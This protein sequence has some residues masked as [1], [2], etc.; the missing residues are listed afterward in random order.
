MKL[1]MCK[2]RRR[3]KESV[4]GASHPAGDIV[5]DE[6]D[7]EFTNDE[8]IDYTPAEMSGDI[9]RNGV[10]DTS[11]EYISGSGDLSVQFVSNEQAPEAISEERDYSQ[12]SEGG[13]DYKVTLQ[14]EDDVLVMYLED[15]NMAPIEDR[16]SFTRDFAK[17]QDYCNTRLH[18]LMSDKDVAL[19]CVSEIVPSIAQNC[20]AIPA[21]CQ[22][23]QPIVRG[24]L[25]L[26]DYSEPQILESNEFRVVEDRSP[27]D[28][29]TLPT[30]MWMVDTI[31]EALDKWTDHDTTVWSIFKLLNLSALLTYCGDPSGEKIVDILSRT[32]SIVSRGPEAWREILRNIS[33]EKTYEEKP[34]PVVPNA[35]FAS[36]CETRLDDVPDID[37]VPREED[38]FRVYWAYTEK[39]LR[40]RLNPSIGASQELAEQTRHW[41]NSLESSAQELFTRFSRTLCCARP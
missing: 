17:L 39:W 13:E 23:C 32:S 4:A 24:C 20:L 16:R 36:R 2:S 40:S 30:G 11:D 22:T 19:K 18:E 8:L 21:E 12:V 3:V 26:G 14:K 33:T 37:S 1:H 10:F 31:N 9:D 41:F 27:M 34:M 35:S 6:S 7:T 38:A 15:L 25:G 5:V 29:P 28:M